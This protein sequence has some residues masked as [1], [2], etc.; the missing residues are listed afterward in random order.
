MV[1]RPRDRRDKNVVSPSTSIPGPAATATARFSSRTLRTQI[2]TARRVSVRGSERPCASFQ[3]AL[4]L[5]KVATVSQPAS[6]AR[7]RT[8]V[9]YPFRSASMNAIDAAAAV[10]E[11]MPKLAQRLE[12]PAD[13]RKRDT[14]RLVPA[15]GDKNG[16]AAREPV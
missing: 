1:P 3:E 9:E 2:A 6:G 4:A 16:P 14:E 8:A 15:T 13:C 5:A 11:M 12:A 10:A 7:A